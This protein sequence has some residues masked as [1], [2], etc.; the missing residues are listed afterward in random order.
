MSSSFRSIIDTLDVILIIL[1]YLLLGF[2]ISFASDWE[3]ILLIGVLLWFFDML[4]EWLSYIFIVGFLVDFIEEDLALQIFTVL[5][6]IWILLLCANIALR[7]LEYL[8]NKENAEN[9]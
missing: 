8:S 2:L 4:P 5:L 9:F 7:I 1:T 3:G 6:G